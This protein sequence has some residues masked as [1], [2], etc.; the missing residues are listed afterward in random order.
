[1]EAFLKDVHGVKEMRHSNELNQTADDMVAK[2]GDPLGR[3]IR[4]ALLQSGLPLAFLGVAA[5][6]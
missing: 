4:V 5:I 3:D 6:W 2:F 1:M